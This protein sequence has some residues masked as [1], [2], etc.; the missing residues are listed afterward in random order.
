MPGEEQ[1]L[2]EFV[3][4]LQSKL[5]G[6][7]V[8]VVFDKMERAG[9]AGSLLKI[10]EEIRDAIEAA[11][12]QWV[13]ETER[14]TD[15]KGQPLLFSRADMERISNKPQQGQLFDLSEIT[16]D[17][18]F[19]QAEVKLVDALRHYAEQAHNGQRLQKRLF[20]EDAV[21]GFA[22]LDLCRKRFDVVLMNPPFGELNLK[23][24]KYIVDEYEHSSS[25][26]LACFVERTLGLCCRDGFVGAI[27]NR[28]CFYL[29]TMA[30]YRKEILQKK[31]RFEALLDLGYGVLDA[32]VEPAAY[33][34]KNV[35]QPDAC[36]PFIR[37]LTDN[38]KGA[39][40]LT[41]I[42]A[43][44]NGVRTPKAFYA[45]PSDFTRL[46]PAPFCYWVPSHVI[47]ALS[48]LPPIE[49]NT[50]RINV[51]LQTGYDW[52]FLRLVWE[53]DPRTISPAPRTIVQKPANIRTAC[54]EELRTDKVWAF[55]SKTDVASPWYSPITLVV[56][57]ESNGHEIKNFTNA[58][59]KVRSRR[60]NEGFY[61]RPGFSYVRR[62]T[63]LVPFVVPSGLIPTAGRSQVYP[64]PG[65]EIDVLGVCASRLG[66]AVAR[67]YGEM[68]ARPLFQASM[69]QSIPAVPIAK[70]T[71]AKLE[72]SINAEI[73]RR[74]WVLSRFE[75]WH[76]F[77]LPALLYEDSQVADEW[78]LD[79]LIGAELEE[80]VARDAG[81]T[82]ADLDLTC[83]DLQ[84]AISIRRKA[85]D[86]NDGADA[87][88][89][90][91]DDQGEEGEGEEGEN[92]EVE[93]SL[94]DSSPRSL[95]AG[96][97]S[98]CVGVAFGRWDVRLALD[99]TLIP[100][101]QDVLDPLP[102]CPPGSL[103]SADGLPATSGKMVSEEWLRARPNAVYLPDP[104]SV[105]RATI[106]DKDYPI[107]V[108]WTG[109][110][111]DD[112]DNSEDI[113]K[114]VQSVLEVMFDKRAAAV[115][116]N[117]CD[118]L[119]VKT[120]REYFRKPGN[121]GFW[122]DHIGQ[123]TKSRRKA[124]IYWMLQSSEKSYGVWLYYHRLDK[125]TLLKA[126]LPKGPVGTKLS[127]EQS[128]LDDLRKKRKAAESDAKAAKKLDREIEAQEELLNEL[129][130]FAEKLEQAAKLEFGDR[131]KLDS[132]VQYNPDHN[133]GVVLN[134]APLQ[135]LVP[136]RE[137]T[138]YW[139]QLLEG[140]HE[141]SSIG[142]LLR[143]K[144]LV[145]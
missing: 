116:K 83:L 7:L 105:K 82:K 34:M 31:V 41:E 6:Q 124:P 74:S 35:R 77:V 138:S 40:A 98:Y 62:T 17:Q 119:D 16:E 80:Q 95:H 26:I 57:W 64:E 92:E 133:D 123:Y 78:Q 18:F 135:E 66:S 4:Q 111:V 8:E 54:L 30:D 37:L 1:M 43:V 127:L 84:E 86:T 38:D 100:K 81:L 145:K 5:L 70:G 23:A 85:K 73:E 58:K 125:E 39:A 75:P 89:E 132:N 28:N 29:T 118:A 126:L 114:R 49:G 67:F 14:A 11:R 96:L 94:I 55:Y 108:N 13:A 45:T 20:A 93:S 50:A 76:E 87:E 52:R 53:V 3:A 109:V 106:T 25:D 72:P 134:I 2:K 131:E 51:G 112:P 144:G 115:E 22:F 19:E 110:L 48:K 128:N 47:T 140:K 59:G 88:G 136:W 36:A 121:G 130:D 107:V 61:F 142:K 65:F 10:E 101:A 9:D 32:M 129:K 69:V 24:K 117:T 113:V 79:S 63:R 139:Q 104:K 97:V 44:N 71:K 103:V 56:K 33:I 15:C 42:G 122:S 90:G 46:I 102:A 99:R 21:R 60:Q 143:K 68:F 27:T 91:D 120:L 12:K 141:W 137:A